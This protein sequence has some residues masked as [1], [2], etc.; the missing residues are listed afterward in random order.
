MLLDRLAVVQIPKED[1]T[2]LIAWLSYF[3][4]FW[5][6][7]QNILKECDIHANELISILS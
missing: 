1:V 3:F 7:K 2:P 6:I 4:T 5:R